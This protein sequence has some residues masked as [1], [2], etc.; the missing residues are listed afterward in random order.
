[1]QHVYHVLYVDDEPDFLRLGKIYLELSGDLSIDTATSAQDMLESGIIHS[2]DAIIS[3]YQ[4]P[5]M[6]GIVFLKQVR[7]RFGDIPFILFTGK[8]REEIVIEAINNGAD[9]YIQKGGNPESQFIELEHK[10]KMAVER[11]RAICAVKDSE[12]RQSDIINFLPDAT[13]AIDLSGTV[14]AW[15]RAMEEMTGVTR[16]AIIGKGDFE[17]AL[18]FYGERRA[19]L[20]DFVIRPNED[21][22]IKYPVLTR[23]DNKLISQLFLSRLYAGRGAYLWFIASPLYDAKG[24]IIGAIESIRDITTRKQAEQELQ[25]AYEQITANEEELRENYDELIKRQQELLASEERYRNVVEDQ[26]E[27]IDR[28]LPDGTH[29]FVNEAYCRYF[30]I[31]KQDLI[32]KKFNPHIPEQDQ[33]ILRGRFAALSH[34]TP[35]N[36]ITHRIIMADGSCCWLRWNDRAIFD[37][38]GMLIEYQSVGRDITVQRLAEDALKLKNDELSAS[39][40]QIATNEI[41]LRKNYAELKEKEKILHESEERYRTVFEN[42]G[43]AM[44]LIENDAIIHL[45]NEEFAHLTGYTKQEIEGKKSWMD[46]VA[47]DDLAMMQYQ[48]RLR[49]ENQK[50]AQKQYEFRL[51]TRS[52]TL[53][54]IFFTI[55]MIPGSDRSVGSLLDITDRKQIEDELRTKNEELY[56]SYEQLT[57]TEEELRQN[58]EELAVQEQSLRQSEAHLEKAQH[59]ATIGSW[60]FDLATGNVAWTK[61]TYR[62]FGI[63]LGR[64]ELSFEELSRWWH[65]DDQPVFLAAMQ[66]VQTTGTPYDL[67]H[68][69]ILPD[70]TQKYLRVQGE[71]ITNKG[72]VV[73]V[74]GTVQDISARKQIEEALLVSNR[75]LNFLSRITRHDILNQLTKLKGYSGLSGECL[76]DPVQLSVFLDKVNQAATAIEYQ[77]TFTRDYQNLGVS[78]PVWRNV[79]KLVMDA[80]EMLLQQTV[81]VT[82][83]HRNPEI[84]ADPLCDKVF[85]YVLKNTRK[86]AGEESSRVQVTYTELG[87]HL[88]I[89]FE[90]PGQG[91]PDEEKEQIFNLGLEKNA[92]NGLFVSREILSITDIA[93]TETGIYTKGVRFEITVPKGMYR[94]TGTD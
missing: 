92:G 34:E 59:Q 87:N 25:T 94:F 77:I 8:G 70:G 28:F 82:I 48:H 32:G 19:L 50:A 56:A 43:T 44:L 3:D 61:E 38:H 39:Y 64:R 68:R 45:V 69:V 31:R 13:F 15:N 36:T 53:R 88:V 40:Q 51:V 86:Y 54:T 6:D 67:E 89:T 30:N 37:H 11:H 75:K 1:M 5:K 52:G 76:D 18:P 80:Q 4:M 90:S 74:W 33:P 17:Y 21:L 66:A 49:R 42:T 78:A 2:C 79:N 47:P 55:D 20:L 91:V 84:F 24:Q 41:A 71:A 83:D 73:T 12:Q 7:A 93:L 58:M 60:I 65:P 72:K 9:F 62:I 23:Q 57:A 14:I 35:T 63:D 29:V 26:T 46:F 81:P 22:T 85:F 16:E 27:L 10:I